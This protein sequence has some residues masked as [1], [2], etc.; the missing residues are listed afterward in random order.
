[1]DIY[2]KKE[3]T[4]SF[5]KENFTFNVGN[6]LFSTFDV[7]HGTD[8]L[9]RSINLHTSPKTILDLGCGYG[10]LGIVLAKKYP[11]AK[12]TMVDRDLLAVR[13]TKLNI[14]KNNIHNADVFGSVGMEQVT[15]TT[16]DLIV[17]NIPAKIGD[18]AITQEFILEPFKQLNP[19][20]ELWVVVVNALNRLIPKIGREHQLNV[21]EVK[22]RSGHT[23]YRIKKL[24]I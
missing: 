3:I 7:D 8:V 6:T 4:Y 15:D 17:S 12:V 10:P 21:K 16:F 18:E 11:Q 19:E 5:N 23:V 22:K 1:M 9:L 14:E 13:Y 24:S 2:F 20:G